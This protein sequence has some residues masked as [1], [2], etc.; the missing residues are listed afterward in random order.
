MAL[1]TVAA[2]AADSEAWTP[3]QWKGVDWLVLDEAGVVTDARGNIFVPY[4]KPDGAVH[5]RKVFTPSGATFWETH[6][7]ELIP[8]GLERLVAGETAQRTAV[9]IAEGESDALALRESFAGTTSDHWVRQISVLGLPGARSWRPEWKAYLEHYP[10]IYLFGDG[11]PAGQEM[12]RAVMRDVPWARPVWLPEGTDARSILQRNGHRAL[13]EL[14]AEADRDAA[15][16]AAFMHARDLD[17]C[18][19]LLRGEEVHRA[20]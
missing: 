17:E 6:G 5:N 20:A 4:R 3:S 14:L 7:L 15:L 18:Q 13:D 12:N 19:R 1:K 9:L 16:N 11:D 10:L 2:V 8:L